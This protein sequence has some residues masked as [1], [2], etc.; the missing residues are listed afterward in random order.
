M[1]LAK[2][3]YFYHMLALQGCYNTRAI[4]FSFFF[5]CK[6]MRSHTDANLWKTTH[7]HTEPVRFQAPMWSCPYALQELKFK[8]NGFKKSN[9]TKNASYVWGTLV[10]WALCIAFVLLRQAAR[11]IISQVKNQPNTFFHKCGRGY[12]KPREY[13]ISNKKCW[14]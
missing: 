4:F 5:F 12:M 10:H 13:S 7:T 8:L 14:G 1:N 6:G 9:I 3:I 2:Q 11:A